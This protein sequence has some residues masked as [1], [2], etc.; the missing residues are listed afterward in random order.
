MFNSF[1]LRRNRMNKAAG[2]GIGVVIV[3][4]AI[5]AFYMVNQSEEST[6]QVELDEGVEMTA[7]QTKGFEVDLEEGVQA[8]GAPP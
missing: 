1:E 2:A 4:I 5:A 3:L 6:T 8:G 7:E